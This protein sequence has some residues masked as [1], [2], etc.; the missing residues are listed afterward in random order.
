MSDSFLKRMNYLAYSFE[1]FLGTMSVGEYKGMIDILEDFRPKRICELGCGQSTLIFET[2]C[3]RYGAELFSIE[4]DERYRR[5]NTVMF[6]LIDEETSIEING[7]RYDSLNKYDGFE[8]WLENQ[9]KFDFVLIDGPFG[10]GLREN[11]KYSRIQLLSFILLDKISDSAY[12]LYHDSE[13]RNAKTTL[14]EFEE[15][16]YRNKFIFRKKVITDRP[17]LTIYKVD[18][19][20]KELGK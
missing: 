5:G 19:I 13:R 3:N 12:I 2:Y 15:L 10:F 6:K 16:L 1:T 4:H 14:S 20:L 17:E 7:R 9:G 11:Y 8:D 18:K